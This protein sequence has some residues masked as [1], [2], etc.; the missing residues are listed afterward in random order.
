MAFLNPPYFALAFGSIMRSNLIGVSQSFCASNALGF[1]TSPLYVV[2]EVGYTT[3]AMDVVFTMINGIKGV[4]I[5]YE[6]QKPHRVNGLFFL[7]EPFELEVHVE[8]HFGLETWALLL[9]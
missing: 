1:K 2:C 5:D 9:S 7:K 4:K 6:C 8:P 3:Q